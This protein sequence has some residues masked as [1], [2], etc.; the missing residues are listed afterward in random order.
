MKSATLK[1]LSLD[2]SKQFVG[3]RKTT[4]K[5]RVFYLHTHKTM[6]VEE[7]NAITLTFHSTKFFFALN[8]CEICAQES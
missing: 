6:N 8:C 5:I 3:K 4:K 7:N 2:L 1:E